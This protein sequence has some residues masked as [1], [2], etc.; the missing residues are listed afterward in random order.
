[1]YCRDC[2]YDLRGNDRGDCPECGL[3]YDIDNSKTYLRRPMKAGRITVLTI[4]LGLPIG[5]ILLSGFLEIQYRVIGY[6]LDA[7]PHSFWFEPAYV[8]VPRGMR[9]SSGP[10]HSWEYKPTHLLFVI[11]LNITFL[12]STTIY[13]GSYLRRFLTGRH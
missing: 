10:S 12:V 7:S 8:S 2:N 11:A 6:W 3:A 1:M 5:L 9:T 4:L 13:A